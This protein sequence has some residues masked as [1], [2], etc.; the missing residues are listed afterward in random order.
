MMMIPQVTIVI[1]RLIAHDILCFMLSIFCG[2]LGHKLWY[3]RFSKAW[4]IAWGKFQRKPRFLP[5][6]LWSFGRGLPPNLEEIP[7]LQDGAKEFRLSP[8]CDPSGNRNQFTLIVH[9]DFL[10]SSSRNGIIIAHKTWGRYPCGYRWKIPIAGWSNHVVGGLDSL[11]KIC[12]YQVERKWNVFETANQLHV[13]QITSRSNSTN[14]VSKPVLGLSKK[15]RPPMTNL[16]YIDCRRSHFLLVHFLLKPH[17]SCCF[18]KS[19]SKKE[20]K[21]SLFAQRLRT[22]DVEGSRDSAQP[23]AFTASIPWK[24]SV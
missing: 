15:I 9:P 13:H 19:L 14:T 2:P 18:F 8:T 21:A 3:P 5:F 23:A 6:N 1:V 12:M 20:V 11:K 24:L 17:S 10:L 7:F 16:V 22:N 4:W